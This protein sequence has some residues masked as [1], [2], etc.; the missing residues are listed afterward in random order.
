MAAVGYLVAVSHAKLLGLSGDGLDPNTYALD[1]GE[2][3]THTLS[4]LGEAIQHPIQHLVAMFRAHP[5][6]LTVAIVLAAAS[7]MHEPLRRRLGDRLPKGLSL[8]WIA[9]VVLLL[10]VLGKFWALDLP[11]GGLEGVAV[12]NSNDASSVTQEAFLQKLAPKPEAKGDFTARSRDLQKTFAER[13]ANHPTGPDARAVSLWQD[14][15]CSRA[16]IPDPKDYPFTPGL[17]A[18][19]GASDD[20]ALSLEAEFLTHLAMAGLIALVAIP[21]LRS[22]KSGSLSVAAAV[23]ALAYTPTAANAY[24][25][26]LK[27]TD[28]D[29]GVIRL[30]RAPTDAAG[31]AEPDRLEGLV[32]ARDSVGTSLLVVEHATCALSDSSQPAP[33]PSQNAG[34]VAAAPHPQLTAVRLSWLPNGQIVSIQEIFR[35]D[36][37]SWAVLNERRCPPTIP[38]STT[39]KP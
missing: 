14:L 32:L 17:V 5:A 8:T 15:L 21:V 2:F 6:L 4:I 10:L 13:L 35:Q 22:P 39:K 7:L 26:L 30:A 12:A 38:R 29:Y 1:A 25:K 31:A 33:A 24:G 19:P 18:C 23:L 27:P 37:I 16:S 36:A 11:L 34:A 9:P 3:F 28:F 20:Y